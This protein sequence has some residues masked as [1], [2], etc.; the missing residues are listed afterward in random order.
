M[1]VTIHVTDIAVV[2]TIAMCSEII[3]I[4]HKSKYSLIWVLVGFCVSPLQFWF[5]T[6]S[7]LCSQHDC[8]MNWRSFHK[9]RESDAST[10]G[11]I[12]VLYFYYTSPPCNDALLKIALLWWNSVTCRLSKCSWTGSF[13]CN[14][15]CSS[16]LLP[17]S[18]TTS[19]ES[20]LAF[21]S[22]SSGCLLKWLLLTDQFPI[23]PSPH[24]SHQSRQKVILQST[25][26]YCMIRKDHQVTVQAILMHS[27]SCGGSNAS[28]NYNKAN[29]TN[30]INNLSTQ[31]AVQ[32]LMPPIS[33]VSQRFEGEYPCSS[34]RESWITTC[35]EHI[36]SQVL[37][38]YSKF[39]QPFAL[40]KAKAT[41]NFVQCTSRYTDSG[42]RKLLGSPLP[43]LATWMD[44][45]K[46][47]S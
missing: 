34:W 13:E 36:V 27:N 44:S 4:N 38:Q 39:C 37:A 22:C 15:R 1:Y 24:N 14:I 33:T 28:S 35:H 5:H 41:E 8:Y 7:Y 16:P 20:S 2:I 25:S 9:D 46:Y 17:Q 12:I 26:S 29:G 31:W 21:S 45:W 40:L 42:I 10:L 6:E 3:T 19:A 30:G 23:Q 32:S 47:H 43:H 11:V 18:G